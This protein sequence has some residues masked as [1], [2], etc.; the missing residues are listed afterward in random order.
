MPGTYHGDRPWSFQT[1][2]GLFITPV[3]DGSGAIYFGSADHNFYALN[4]DGSLRWK[5]ATGGIIDAAAALGPPAR[6]GGS[7]TIGSADENLYDLS[8]DPRPLTADQRV[9]WKYH[10]TLKPATGQ[11]VDWWEDDLAYGPDGNVYTGNTGGQLGVDDAVVR[12]RRRHL[13]GVGRPVD[14]S[15]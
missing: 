4:P 2:R 7:V 1:G 13:L 5:F 12:P 9:L 15:P 10:A 14:P 8:T 3:V 11:L 6:G